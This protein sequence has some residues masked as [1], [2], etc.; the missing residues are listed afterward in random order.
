M[1][2][3]TRR[4]RSAC[5]WLPSPGQRLAKKSAFGKNDDFKAIREG[6]ELS[7]SSVGKDPPGDEA[8]G[9]VRERGTGPVLPVSRGPAMP[10]ATGADGLSFSLLSVGFWSPDAPRS[11]SFLVPSPS[12]PSALSGRAWAG[13]QAPPDPEAHDHFPHPQV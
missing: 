13:T 10:E 8:N 12:L 11:G 6:S 3:P 5:R 9:A 2:V 4:P 7:G 1:S